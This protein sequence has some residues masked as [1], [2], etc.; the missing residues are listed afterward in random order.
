MTAN[1]ESPMC[2]IVD[3]CAHL[4]L[5]GTGPQNLLLDYEGKK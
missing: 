4:G 5:E 1:T 2:E 3:V